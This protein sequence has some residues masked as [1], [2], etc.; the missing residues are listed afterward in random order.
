[1]K[2][3][4]KFVRYPRAVA[5]G[6]FTLIELLVVIAVIAI[7]AGLL[8]PSLSQ[9]KQKAQAIQCL[10]NLRQ[11]GIAWTLY[12]GDNDDRVPPNTSSHDG[13]APTGRDSTWV[14]GYLDAASFVPDN[15]NTLFITEGHLWP[16]HQQLGIW[17]CPADKSTTVLPESGRAVPRA[18][19]VAM[20][21]WMNCLRPW[22][23][24]S[25]G[26]NFKIIQKLG[27]MTTPAPVNTFLLLDEREDSINDGH[28][29]V[30]MNQ[31][32]ANT[33][34]VDFPA[35][36]H[37][38]AAAVNFADGH[39]IIKRWQDPRTRPPLEKGR[40][41]ELNIPSPNNPDVAWLQERATGLR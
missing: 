13:G 25:G 29:V 37:H 34:L 33:Y 10:N 15:T 20:N 11:L 31:T 39:M 16:Y 28:F 38:G 32:G 22:N 23:V 14:Q 21:K 6:G 1:M 4:S 8:L 35:S 19:S 17:R 30:T 26:E 18:R 36:Y 2:T 9:A 12:V 3:A 40:N 27:D 5:R 41:L 7:L 24:G